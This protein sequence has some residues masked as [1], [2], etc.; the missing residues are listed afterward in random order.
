MIYRQFTASEPLHER[1]GLDSTCAL[2]ILILCFCTPMV[3]AK[4]LARPSERCSTTS[5]RPSWFPDRLLKRW[6]DL[7]IK[8]A[9]A[10]VELLPVA[11][12]LNTW[13]EVMFGRD[14]LVFTDNSSVKEGLVS[15]TSRNLASRDL[16]L[17]ISGQLVGLQGRT[18][19]ARVPSRSNP[20]DAP[21]RGRTSELEEWAKVTRVT[22]L[23]P[24][25]L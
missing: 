12:A 9:I 19:I 6:R 7:S 16:L 8:H 20:A 4:Y 10:Q 1:V 18:W 2:G 21:S 25:G 23:L 24:A 15:G 11:V 5:L 22:P 17:L 13:R 14:L 3:P